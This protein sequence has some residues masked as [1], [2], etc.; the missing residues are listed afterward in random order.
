MANEPLFLEDAE[1]VCSICD[2]TYSSQDILR[3]HVAKVH[4]SAKPFQCD[5]CPR[6]YK[7]NKSL[8]IHRLKHQGRLSAYNS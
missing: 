4:S 1:H 8:K 2:K 6:S 5:L 7:Y 3:Y